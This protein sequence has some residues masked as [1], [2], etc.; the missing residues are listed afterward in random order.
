MIVVKIKQNSKTPAY[1]RLNN[2][3]QA[4]TFHYFPSVEHSF[5]EKIIVYC[6]QF[7][8]V[9]YR[10]LNSAKPTEGTQM[11]DPSFIQ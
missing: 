5:T 10:A 2:K 11:S 8:C 1:M 9:Y 6:I 3:Y 4:H 7:S